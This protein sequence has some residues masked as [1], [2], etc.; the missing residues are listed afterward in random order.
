MD[1]F[2]KDLQISADR[3]DQIIYEFLPKQEGKQ[4]L[5]IEAMNYS[6]TAGG[7]RIRPLLMMETCR[8]FNGN[9]ESIKPFLTAMEMIHTS[10]LVHD[11]LP[12]LDNDEYRRGKKTT[13][14]AY[15]EDMAIL[16]G[17]GLINYAYE[18]CAD[19]LLEADDI[20]NYSRAFVVLAKKSGIYGMLGGQSV[21]VHMSNRPVSKDQ[22]EF[23][24]KLKTSALIEGSMMIGA[25][26]AGASEEQVSLIEQIASNVGMAFQIQDDILDVTS[27]K[28]VL[29]KPVMSDSK[30]NK[31]TYVGLYGLETAKE[32]VL[33]L[34]KMALAQLNSLHVKNDFLEKLL[35]D[36]MNR[37]K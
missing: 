16:A 12:A 18:I 5:I 32:Q 11:D 1:E 21:D 28:E 37:E 19:G 8:L 4:E 6:I 33:T 25:I 31:T 34:S 17:D 24:Y 27:T 3:I 20:K 23:I 15:G 9:M 10:S 22:L 29:G 36:L 30:N 13:H 2:R 35:I 7:K 26:M 14:A